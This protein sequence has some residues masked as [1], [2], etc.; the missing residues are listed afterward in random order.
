MRET[1]ALGAG[2][3]REVFGQLPDGTEVERIRLHGVKGF[4]LAI[5]AF[6]AAV[7]SLQVPDREG[8][9]ADIVLGHDDLAG[10]LARRNMF[11]ASVGRCANRIAGGS[12]PL[13]GRRVQVT[14]NNGPNSLHGGEAGFDRRLWSVEAVADTPSPSVTFAY[15]SLDGEEGYPGTLS[16]RVTYAITEGTGFSIAFEAVT[17]RPTV[18]NLTHHSFFNLGGVAA[19][20]AVLDHELHI[21]ANTY[22]P[23]D[24]TLIPLGGPA[25][26]A[27]TPFDFTRPQAIGARIRDGHEQ[28]RLG[29]GYDHNFC[30]DGGRTSQPRLAARIRHPASGR[31][32]ELLTD[33]PGLQLY[34][35]NFLDG[36]VSGKNGR[37]HRQSDAFCLEP[38][39]WPDAPNRPDFPSVRLDPGQVYKHLS[40]YRF[41]AT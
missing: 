37:L 18:V 20:E 6:G 12:F 14:V 1:R 28:I 23:V 25:P 30:L 16:A 5:V 11:G 21:V 17:N 40:V 2:L 26:V 4:E 24:H 36:T 7:Q 33:Q 3:A 38:Q 41:F 34:T 8:R 31:T 35:G 22:L 13:D 39:A 32:M 27:G 19:P 15:V 29:R 10:Y 9:S